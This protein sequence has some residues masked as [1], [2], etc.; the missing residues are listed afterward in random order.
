MGMNNFTG[1]PGGNNNNPGNGGIPGPGGQMQSILTGPDFDIEEFC[2]NYNQKYMTNGTAPFRDELVQ[3]TLAILI[4][5]KKPNALLVGDAGTGKT[6]IVE[7]IAFRLANNDPIIPDQLKGY[8]IY[9]LPLSNIVAGSSFVGQLEEKIKFVIDFISDKKNKA[10]LFIDEIHMLMSGSNTYEKIAQILKP[11]LA[12]G[13]LHCIGATTTQES[14]ELY[15]DPAFN[16]RF[17]RLI[18][19]ELTREQT[20]EILKNMR[21]SM[22]MHYMNKVSITDEALEQVVI[23]AD[24]YKTVGSHRPDNAITLLDRTCGDAIVQRKVQEQA[25]ANNP[26]ILAAIQA[27]TPIPITPT[28]VK[29]VAMKLMT[30]NNKKQALDVDLLKEKLSVIKGQDDIMDDIIKYVKRHD[31][32]L[33]PKQKPTVMLFAGPSGVGK[34]EVAKIIANVLT[35][36]KP[37]ILNMTEYNTSA[38]VNRIIGAPAGYVGSDSHTELP[39]DCLSSNPYQVILLDEFEKCH[40]V[41]RGLFMSAFEEGIIKT[42]RGTDIDFSK[43]LIIATTNA[44]HTDK[45]TAGIGFCANNKKRDQKTEIK[46]LSKTI[47]TE[48]LNRFTTRITFNSIDKSVYREILQNTYH[49][50]AD[51]I[52]TEQPR[53]K[54]KLPADIPDADLDKM[55]E[56]TYIESFGARPANNAVQN[57][58]EELLL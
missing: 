57:Y 2:I 28:M 9:E 33:Y 18:V 37:I 48:L 42:N 52:R 43:C 5:D 4:A 49:R 10:I 27:V 36:T 6:K 58:I 44:S 11:A 16:R 3:Q 55:V 17:T 32:D 38:E 8:T 20:L 35:G 30:G 24:Q 22:F 21:G 15:A 14:T 29:N 41:V 53:Y 47:K 12:R 7:D 40:E 23:L 25:Y 46:E 51:R 50:D 34:S 19:D 45:T 1:I 54:S 39:F 56:E 13:E 26:T 31:S